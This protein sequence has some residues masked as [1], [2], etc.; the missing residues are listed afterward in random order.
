MVSSGDQFL[1][2][3]QRGEVAPCSSAGGE[4][5]FSIG[6]DIGIADRETVPADATTDRYRGPPRHPDIKRS[7]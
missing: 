1:I 4:P 5:E 6:D 3:E 7:R 2:L